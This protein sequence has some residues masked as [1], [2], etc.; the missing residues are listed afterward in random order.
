MMARHSDEIAKRKNFQSQFEGHF[1]SPLFPGLE[2][3]PPAFA[4]QAPPI[5]DYNLP[6]VISIIFFS[7]LLVFYKYIKIINFFNFQLCLEDLDILIKQLPQIARV[8]SVPNFNAIT[9]FFLSKSIQEDGTLAIESNN[10]HKSVAMETSNL[11]LGD[12]NTIEEKLNEVM[13]AV[14]LGSC[15][16]D[17]QLESDVIKRTHSEMY[18]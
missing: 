10:D 6:K 9:Q 18:V 5:F 1:L 14:G 2:D 16:I 13:T 15:K 7:W 11:M 17:M 8:T 12:M 3:M 4:T